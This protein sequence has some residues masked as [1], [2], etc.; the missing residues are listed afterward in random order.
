MFNGVN[1][2]VGWVEYP[3]KKNPHFDKTEVLKK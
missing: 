3:K 2:K 1:K